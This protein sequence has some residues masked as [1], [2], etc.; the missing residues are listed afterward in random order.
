[1]GN[2]SLQKRKTINGKRSVN[3]IIRGRLSDGTPNPIDL[4]VGTRV[5]MRRSLLGMS[6]ERLASELGVTFQ[7]VQKYERGLNRIGASRLWDLAQ[8]LGVSVDFFY[9]DIDRQT[10]D[11][12][13]RKIYAR[14]TLSEDSCEF[15]MD[16]L[17][18]KDVT[19]LLRAYTQITDPKIQ[20]NILNLVTALAGE[21]DSDS[22]EN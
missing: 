18:R 9:Q 2:K 10:S 4:Y 11:Q 6:Q 13:P 19:A 22:D 17:L 5:R 20:H 8:V 12:S 7:Q 14:P 16:T 3:G 15:D 1:M 21:K